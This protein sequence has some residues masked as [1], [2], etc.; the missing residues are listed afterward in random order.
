MTVL[1]LHN[2]S[3]QTNAESV[4]MTLDYRFNDK[5]ILIDF[6]TEVITIILQKMVFQLYFT[7]PEHTQIITSQVIHQTKL[8]TIYWK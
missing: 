6:T 2:L 4:N 1:Y 3:E 7:L 5:M 8:N